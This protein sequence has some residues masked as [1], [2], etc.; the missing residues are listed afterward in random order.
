M[1]AESAD[2]ALYQE[3]GAERATL[4][5]GFTPVKNE[6]ETILGV[7]AKQFK[8]ISMIAQGEFLKLLYADSTERGNIFRR[9]FHTDLYAAFQ[10]RLK[11]AEREKRIALEDSEKQLLRHFSEMT[12]GSLE[13][14]STF[15]RGGAAFRA[16]KTLAGNGAE[17]TGNRRSPD[18]T[19]KTS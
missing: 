6:I 15:R 3:S 19:A 4:A 17:P 11:D 13:K 7:D 8:Q 10:K 12:G 1:T 18:N 16:G 2:A 14:G 9:V 5:T